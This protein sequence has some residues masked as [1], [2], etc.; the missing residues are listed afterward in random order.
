[1]YMLEKYIL[2]IGLYLCTH[3][4]NQVKVTTAHNLNHSV[5]QGACKQP[6]NRETLRIHTHMNINFYNIIKEKTGTQ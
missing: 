5:A 1:M 2:F 3:N 4:N 6:K